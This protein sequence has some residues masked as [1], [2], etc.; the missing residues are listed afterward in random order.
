MHTVVAKQT[1]SGFRLGALSTSQGAALVRPL[2]PV[3]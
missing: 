1:R 2:A 3:R